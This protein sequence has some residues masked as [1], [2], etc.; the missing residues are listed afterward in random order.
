VTLAETRPVWMPLAACSG[1][2]SE[3]FHPPRGENARAA[4]AVCWS[5]RV[6]E[7]CL[8]WALRTG[9][10]YGI[11]GGMSERDRRRLRANPA[12]AGGPRVCDCCGDTYQP[13]RSDQ[14]FC[15]TDCR[16][17]RRRSA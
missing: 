5:C 6:R 16:R 1:L 2:D 7:D 4:K 13:V 3:L 10:H 12:V 17:Y 11:W 8:D 14:R 9:Q 15:S